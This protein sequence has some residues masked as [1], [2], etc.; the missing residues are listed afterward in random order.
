[1]DISTTRNVCVVSSLVG[2]TTFLISVLDSL[3][4]LMELD[5]KVVVAKNIRPSINRKTTPNTL[6]K[7]ATSTK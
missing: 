7:K 4:N 2:H 6:Y 5:P 3:I 1:M